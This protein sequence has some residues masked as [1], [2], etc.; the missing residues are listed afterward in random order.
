MDLFKISYKAHQ[1]YVIS[2]IENK[3]NA[4]YYLQISNKILGCDFQKLNTMITYLKEQNQEFSLRNDHW[5]TWDSSPSKYTSLALEH[6]L[7]IAESLDI[8]FNKGW[9]KAYILPNR[10]K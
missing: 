9:S 3:K 2:H 7:E 4:K 8:R 1:S 6:A 10:I 5:W